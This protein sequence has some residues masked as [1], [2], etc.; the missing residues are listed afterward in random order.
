MLVSCLL[1]VGW[2]MVARRAGCVLP[3]V[4]APWDV[5]ARRAWLRLRPRLCAG[6]RQDDGDMFGATPAGERAGGAAA[7]PAGGAARR[8]LLDNYDDAEGYYNFQARGGAGGL[9]GHGAARQASSTGERGGSLTA[10]RRAV[11]TRVWE[12]C[13]VVALCAW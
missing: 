9:R 6:G 13:I 5:S 7:A 10:P 12:L 3:A 1:N 4:E 11:A 2:R 8:G